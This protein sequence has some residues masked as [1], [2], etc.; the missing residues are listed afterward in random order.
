MIILLVGGWVGFLWVLVKIGVL[1]KWHGWMK[2]SPVVIG[3]VAFLAIFLPLNWYAPSG[4]ASVTVGSVSIRPAVSGQVTAI[5]ATSWERL[6]KGDPILEIDKTRYQAAFRQAEAKL[7]LA[8]E[9]L[10]RKE[11]LLKGSTVSVAEVDVFRAEVEIAE[12]AVSTARLDLENTTIRAP[13]AGIVP[14]LTIL[15]GYEATAGSP[16]LA[17]LDNEHPIVNLLLGQNQIRN[18][19]IGQKAE[20]TFRSQPG[21]T[22][23]GTV[24]KIYLSAP[25]AEY[26]LDGQTPAVPEVQDTSYVAVIDIGQAALTLPPGASGMGAIYSDKGTKFFF[27]QQ[28]SVRMS[29][30][31]NFF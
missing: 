5:L 22:F 29:A 9:Q 21:K 1:K 18:V 2:V 24:Q 30:W 27:V 28:L 7:N 11:A 20:V 31:M 15:T 6:E 23:E 25:H 14:G 8:R 12:A 3:V 26:V 4:A 19:K 16:I 17:F 10:T 13:F